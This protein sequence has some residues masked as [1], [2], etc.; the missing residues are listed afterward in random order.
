MDGKYQGNREK[1]DLIPTH[2]DKIFIGPAHNVV[3]GDRN[4]VNAS[5]RRL[6]DV[7]TLQ[8]PDVPD[9]GRT[10]QRFLS[11]AGICS[12]LYLQQGNGATSVGLG[13]HALAELLGVRGPRS[14]LPQT[15]V[16]T[17]GCFCW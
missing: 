15:N 8:A 1:G 9:L 17:W 16:R 11:T 12:V 3:V 4:G 14:T 7:D 6:Q 5:A 10:T 13:D 2:V